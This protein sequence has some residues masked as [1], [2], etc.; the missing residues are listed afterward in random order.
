MDF[1][2]FSSLIQ[3]LLHT[4]VTRLS[5]EGCFSFAEAYCHLPVLQTVYTSERLWQLSETA[6]SEQIYDL[7]DML[8]VNALV[9]KTEKWAWIVG[10]FV[11]QEFMEANFSSLLSE[12]GFA[13]AHLP[14]LKLYYSE[15][16]LLSRKTAAD[17]VIGIMKSLLTI[18]A[19]LTIVPIRCDTSPTP[20]SYPSRQGSIDYDSI[21]RRYEHENRFMHAIETGDTKH[22]LAAFE[23]MNTSGLNSRRY[24]SAIYQEPA[25][26]LAILRT[27]ARKAAERGGASVVQIDEITQRATQAVMNASSL[28]KTQKLTETMLMELTEAVRLRREQFAGLSVPVQ[29]TVEYLRLNYSQELS[30]TVLSEIAGLS[31]SY[32]STL[33]RKETGKTITDYLTWLR[34]E[35]A[36]RLL[37]ETGLPIQDISSFVGYFDNNYFI[38]VFRRRFGKAPGEYRKNGE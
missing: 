26:A 31:A 27:L 6:S 4:T 10:P 3:N 17:T 7:R 20:A 19:P 33:F 12:K 14:S 21:Y 2:L 37:R 30:L 35:Q 24:V 13:A 38:K 34:L 9:L 11:S 25:V 18:P 16:P 28:Y 29:K 23:N 15:L 32:L 36:S 5:A 8:G 22:I 1:D